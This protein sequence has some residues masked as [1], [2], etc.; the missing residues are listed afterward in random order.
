MNFGEGMQEKHSSGH[1]NLNFND[2]GAVLNGPGPQC[3][4]PFCEGR[5]RKVFLNLLFVFV[6]F[7]CIISLFFCIFS[8]FALSHILSNW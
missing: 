5:Y 1:V 7:F 3:S 2:N 8:L 4:E 6:F